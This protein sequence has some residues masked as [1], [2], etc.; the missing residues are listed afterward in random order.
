MSMLF[1]I[2][3]SANGQTLQK[4]AIHKGQNRLICGSSD[5]CQIIIKQP[6]VSRQHMEIF[7]TRDHRIFVSDLNSTNGTFVNKKRIQAGEKKEIRKGDMVYMGVNGQVQLHFAHHADEV[8]VAKT[9]G[10]T[11]V[12]RKSVICIGRDKTCDIHIDSP[13]ASRSHAYIR[14]NDDG[15]YLLTDNNSTNGT[16]INGVLLTGSKIIG[17]DDRIKIGNKSFTIRDYLSNRLP[18][19][20]VK[21]V[22]FISLLN[23]KPEI[24][25]GRSRSADYKISDFSVSMKHAKIVKRN[26][27]YYI[28][29]LNSTNGTFVNNKRIKP[30]VFVPIDS[31]DEIR[32]SLKTFKL[33]GDS[34]DLS[35]YSA[36]NT[37]QLT[38]V[39]YGKKGNYV[40]VKS[41]SF[42]I[43]SKSFIAL[44][45]PS[46]CGKSTLMNMLNGSNPATSG[47]VRISGL[48][49][50]QNIDYL[51]QIIGYVPQD[52]IVH[53]NLKVD[54]ALYY[55]AKL[56]MIEDATDKEIENRITE[57][58]NNL[59]ITKEQRNSYVSNLSGGQR[60]RVSIAVE[61]LNKP[62]VLFL[63]E[64]TSPLDP[65][66]IDNFLKS[67][68][69]L[70]HKEGT[71]V[72]MVTHKP[73][74][75]K[76]VDRVIFM[77]AKGYT[78][79][80][81]DE[82][83]MM[84]YFNVNH[85]I[86]VYS[87]L[88]DPD[89]A[90]QW[91]DKWIK[92][93]TAE[94]L[95]SVSTENRKKQKVSLFHQFYWLT[96]RYA[97]LKLNDKQNLLILL[98]QPLL[99]PLALV[100]IYGKLE[101]GIIFLMAITSIWFGVSNAAKEIV[102]EIP[103]YL[104][105]RM[106]N[107]KILPY[108]F[109]K[110]TILSLIALIQIAIYVAVLSMKYNN[111]GDGEMVNLPQ[112][113]LFMFYLTFSATLLG[114]FLSVK[115]KT[116]EQVMSIIPIMLIPQIIFAGVVSEIDSKPKEALSYFMYGR[117]GTEGLSRI[118]SDKASFKT[119]PYKDTD[120]LV[121][122][123]DE[124]NKPPKLITVE[125]YSGD[126]YIE[127]AD[128][129]EIDNKPLYK[130]LYQK[131]PNVKSYKNTYLLINDDNKVDDEN[132]IPGLIEG[133]KRSLKPI[134]YVDG[135]K[136]QKASP[137]KILGFDHNDKLYN[138]FNSLNKN[139]LAISLINF[140]IFL[141]TLL[142][143]KKKDKI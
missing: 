88:S 58:C 69:E 13:L 55:A 31:K 48:D 101:L 94:N 34:T 38:K 14:K 81:G 108:Y 28:I 133:K 35:E 15:T 4:Y 113:F 132:Y 93:N 27:R 22:D 73:G 41:I 111:P 43:P 2:I 10:K 103:I 120:T 142:F 68:R 39:Y 99:I 72:V 63:D 114:L 16:Y 136:Y 7:I 11:G 54:K 112:V 8:G 92:T 129:I 26:N 139:I 131:V 135:K 60:K 118:Q 32:I 71:T 40:A 143:I 17:V 128:D 49:L 46:G 123:Y 91:Y 82:K 130:S 90:K 30:Q 98:L 116:T 3:I 59:N 20:A 62:S 126:N 50:I 29:D 125:D 75:L 24:V 23:K 105:E 42:S 78:T 104:R 79:Y 64:P 102:E 117:W 66:T 47:S 110:L 21:R 5:A 107:L 86:E 141:L 95:K 70:A 109:S 122:R 83:N 119:Y 51:K 36:I 44:M 76:Y 89:A 134:T 6:V 61:L 52:D 96:V 12:T 65:E 19:K 33:N 87:K 84:K 45:G 77:G 121:Y 74:D 18:K 57:V 9:A 137:L 67:I 140:V 106:Y 124:K 100:F 80:Y 1:K 97:N 138:I 53:K 56:R 115:F 85:I 25:I 37:E 127:V